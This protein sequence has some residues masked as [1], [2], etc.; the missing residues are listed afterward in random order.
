MTISAPSQD[1]TRRAKLTFASQI[2]AHAGQMAA[3]LLFTPIIVRGLDKELYGAWGMITG[4]MGFLGLADLNATSILK[5]L[6]GIR[7]H[8]PDFAEKRRLIGAAIWQWVIFLPLVLLVGALLVFFAPR[9]VPISPEN[10]TAV[11]WTM[12]LM[13]VSIPLAQLSSIPGS[14]LAGQNLEYK[15]MG[16]NAAMVLIGG[17]MNALGVMAGFGL[18]VLAVTSL[19]G[20][21]L[22]N[23]ARLLIAQRNLPWFGVARPR[24][25]EILDLIRLS[26]PG[27]LGA[28]K[29]SLLNSA[30]V[31]LFGYCFGTAAASVYMITGALIRYLVYPLQE[32][33]RSGN[34]GIIFLGGKGEWHRLAAL[35]LELQQTALWGFG[36]MAAIVLSCNHLFVHLWVGERF[37][38]GPLLD[39]AIVLHTSFRQMVQIDGIPLDASLH[40]YPKEAMGIAWSILGLMVGWSLTGVIGYAGIPLG[41][42][43]GQGGLWGTYQFLLR[44]YTGLP[45]GQHLRRMARPLG[46]FG[47]AMSG[48]AWVRWHYTFSATTWFG[49]GETITLVTLVA[50]I[51]CGVLGLSSPVRQ[52]LWHRLGTQ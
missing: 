13:T 32:L 31:L 19:I 39:V 24:K 4:M 38:G 3:G 10:L 22:V 7:Q 46:V 44:R 43:L 12:A 8:N 29:G 1:L 21:L 50:G 27:S 30:D 45:I 17:A 14:V 5:L 51:G 49:L 20:I 16:L 42:A 41:V 6:L 36:V 25:V 18:V 47:L 15:A 40:L 35:R 34:A 9:L 52:R 26:I 23:G 11:Y 2:L 28:A 48:W 37:Y 33:L